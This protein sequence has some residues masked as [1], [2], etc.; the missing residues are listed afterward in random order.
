MINNKESMSDL[1]PEAQ[2][3]KALAHILGRIREDSRV[4]WYLGLGTESF[5][6]ATEALASL[7]HEPVKN[8]RE[9]YAPINPR[10][11]AADDDERTI[12]CANI[13]E[14]EEAAL[15]EVITLLENQAEAATV[16]AAHDTHH[17]AF[18]ILTQARE[19]ESLASE[20]FHLSL[21]LTKAA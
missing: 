3:R 9:A 14:D 18:A 13:S 4:G 21:K 8:V 6:L 5:A 2:A 15:K 7:T 11:P 17:D 19:K 12:V 10:N 1:A 16:A 20:L